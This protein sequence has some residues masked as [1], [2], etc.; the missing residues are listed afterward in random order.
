MHYT[1]Q[2]LHLHH[3][4]LYTLFC[5]W[6][7]FV[8]VMCSTLYS[9]SVFILFLLLNKYTFY[10]HYF[11]TGVFYYLLLTYCPC[12]FV[13]SVIQQFPFFF[14][15]G[16]GITFIFFCLICMI[17]FYYVFVFCVCSSYFRL[18]A[19]HFFYQISPTNTTRLWKCLRSNS[20]LLVVQWC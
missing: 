17:F 5:G 13:H 20:A 8:A 10:Y 11:M 7:I 15:G 6:V 18:P 19:K 16:G 1:S 14:W 2:R 12:D 9:L 3:C 4:G